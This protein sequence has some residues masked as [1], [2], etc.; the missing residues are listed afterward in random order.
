MIIKGGS[1]SGPRQL[2]Y[3]LQRADTNERVEVLE[4]VSPIDNLRETFRDWQFLSTG[5]RGSKGL[6]H[7]NIDP[8]EQYSMTREQW[9]HAADVLEKELGLDGQPRAIVMHEKHGRTHLHVVWQRTDID[10]MTLRSDSWNYKAHERASL[11]LELELGHDFVPGK[12]AKRDPSR[13]PPKEALTH[14]EWQ[15]GERANI[16]P[17]ERKA[18]ITALYERCDSGSAFKVALENDGYILAQGDRRDF[19]LIDDQGQVH[20]LGRQVKDVKAAELRAFMA[21]V[22]RESLP[23]VEQGKALQAEREQARREIVPQAFNEAAERHGETGLQPA[24]QS[25]AAPFAPQATDRSLS[26]HWN[27]VAS[28]TVQSNADS[29]VPS[30][31]RGSDSSHTPLADETLQNQREQEQPQRH[32]DARGTDHAASDAHGP[33]MQGTPATHSEPAAPPAID[34]TASKSGEA[35]SSLAA[36]SKEDALAPPR[37]GVSK[38]SLAELDK[39]IAERFAADKQR[40]E[41]F[42]AAERVHLEKVLTRDIAEKMK[43]LDVPQEQERSRVAADLK[44]RRKGIDGV[45][46][47]MSKA[48]NPKRAAQSDAQRREEW[49]ALK[50]KQA[51][52]RAD[53]LAPL[54][55][56]AEKELAEL[57]ERH[58]QQLRDLTAR[59]EQDRERHLRNQENAERLRQEIDQRNREQNQTR[60]RDGPPKDPKHTR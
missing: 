25:E 47:K 60:S 46:Y 36:Q 12:H 24:A 3:H 2:A 21:D 58:A 55:R 33:E 18:A 52:E 32:E 49:E 31:L 50:A 40:L 7:A 28:P 30:R 17:R 9:L 16:N 23:D 44:S 51:K 6:Y 45:L 43:L 34:R 19:V 29:F 1:R 57:A 38:S 5:T 27:A 35:T 10:T 11:T 4:L 41:T 22:D 13:A 20:S 15:Q 42:H 37:L 26:E 54:E 53:R 48:V 56:E 39:A 59:A 14:A 8:A